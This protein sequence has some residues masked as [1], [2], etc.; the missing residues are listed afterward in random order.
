MK[1]Q[2]KKFSFFHRQIIQI[3]PQKKDLTL[4][5]LQDIEVS[6]AAIINDRLFFCAKLKNE[7]IEQ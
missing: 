2:Y 1:N 5:S 7:K 4:S 3:K 6:S